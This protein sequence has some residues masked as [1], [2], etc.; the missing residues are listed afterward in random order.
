ME[1]FEGVQRL[2]A[3]K[4]IEELIREHPY[5]DIQLQEEDGE[6][7]AIFQT[8]KKKFTKGSNPK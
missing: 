2:K 6:V 3:K 1:K 4:R 8:I 7:I 5:Q